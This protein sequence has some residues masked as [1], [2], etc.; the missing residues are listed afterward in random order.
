MPGFHCRKKEIMSVNFNTYTY[1]SLVL[2][3]SPHQT[4]NLIDEYN[5]LNLVQL[6]LHIKY[7]EQIRK[8]MDKQIH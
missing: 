6:T 1:V 4:G 3:F 8:T 5:I 2:K 7:Q